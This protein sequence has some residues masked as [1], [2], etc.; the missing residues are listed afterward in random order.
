MI[1]SDTA[2]LVSLRYIACDAFEVSDAAGAA[3]G[4]LR[5]GAACFP[6]IC[7]GLVH[8]ISCQVLALRGIAD[9]FGNI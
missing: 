5:G 1:E 7:V 2:E 6:D 8:V 4:A 3:Q 9:D